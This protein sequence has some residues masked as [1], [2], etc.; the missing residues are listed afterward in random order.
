MKM[1]NIKEKQITYHRYMAEDWN[2]YQEDFLEVTVSFL[3]QENRVMEEVLFCFV[4]SIN[5][6]GKGSKS[7][8][9]LQEP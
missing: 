9:H 8:A 3:K 6:M 7:V 5:R 4:E 2:P 1:E